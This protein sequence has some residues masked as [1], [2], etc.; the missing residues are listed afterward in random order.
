M[1]K[2]TIT[3][4]NPTL[5]VAQNPTV[6]LQSAVSLSS[7]AA[8]AKPKAIASTASSVITTIGQGKSLFLGKKQERYIFLYKLF[9]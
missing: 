8:T 7:A 6:S 4:E 1:G 9:Y 3:T 5:K 2:K